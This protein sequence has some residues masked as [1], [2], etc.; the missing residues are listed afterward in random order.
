MP[1]PEEYYF[2]EGCYI[3]EWH[4]SADD[5]S[6]SVARVRV[7]GLS[8]TRLHALQGTEERY[9]ILSG[10][11]QTTVGDS[12][13]NVGEGDVVHIPRN[14]PQKIRNTSK[15]DLVFLAMCSPRFRESNYQDLED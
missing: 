12:T 13:R 6:C 11:G 2:K 1:R 9:V 14:T 10:Q 5:E 4:N 7:E 15:E 8:E 3:E